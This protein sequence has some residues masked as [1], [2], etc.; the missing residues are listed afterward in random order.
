MLSPGSYAQWKSRF[1]RYV[2]TKP[3]RELLKKT[4]YEGPYIMTGI[5]LLETPEDGDRPRVPGYTKKETY[6]NTGP[7]NRKLIDA[8]AE[9]VHMILN[10]IRNDIYSIVDACPNAKKMDREL[11]ESYYT[12][13]YRMMNEMVRNKLKVDNMQ[14]NVQFLQQLQP[15]WSKF[16]TIVKQA[17]NLDNV[18]YHTLFNI[19]KQHQNEVNEIRA[20][21]IA[22]NA[23]PLALVAA[24]QNHPDDYYKAPPEPKPYKPHTPSSRQKTSTRSNATTKHKDKEIVKQPS[25]QSESASEEDSDEEHAQ[26]DK[27][28]Q[29]SLTLTAKY[30]KNIYKPTNN[31]HR[32]SS[33]TKNKNVDTSPRTRNDRNT[34]QF[35][36]QRTI[37]V[38]GNRETVGNQDTDEDP[39]E[40]EL[41]AHYMYMTKIQEVLHATDDKSRPT[42]DGDPLEK[43]DI[44]DE[45]NVFST[46]KQHSKQ[47]ESINNT[48]VVEKIDSNVIPDS[49]NMCDNE[50][51]DD[52]NAEVLEN[53][54][55]LL[56]SLI[57]KLKLYVD[58]NKKIQK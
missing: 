12:R 32:T 23:N 4:I 13:F 45:Y 1:M 55:V 18:S 39:D 56:T 35:R 29:K 46:K 48:Y 40:Q 25:P 58:E 34:G 51:K 8:E 30:F 47:P 2:D 42:Y 15:E 49:T 20:E 52:Q 14:V 21:R 22:R 19:L 36:N 16:V 41:E 38:A 6:A 28:I 31:N 5:T 24:T 27:Q 57:A 44:D 3:N 53:E 54:R 10:G 50:T 37:A 9:A 43:V 26:R 11:I 33:N 17:N 7:E